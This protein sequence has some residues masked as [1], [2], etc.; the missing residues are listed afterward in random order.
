[1]E[2]DFYRPHEAGKI[3][4][5]TTD[6]VMHL[7]RTKQLTA[8]RYD[9]WLG[10][11]GQAID[12]YQRVEIQRLKDTKGQRDCDMVKRAMKNVSSRRDVILP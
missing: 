6:E 10:T 11:T 3:L 7:L 5:M 1:M 9:G 2:T 4:G 12:E 8:Y